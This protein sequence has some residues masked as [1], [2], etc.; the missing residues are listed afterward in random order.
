MLLWRFWCQTAT[1][2]LGSGSRCIFGVRSQDSIWSFLSCTM[3]LQGF[4]HAL[5]M[6]IILSRLSL[7]EIW[8]ENGCIAEANRTRCYVLLVIWPEF[9]SKKLSLRP[10]SGRDVEEQWD[11]FE[12]KGLAKKKRLL[13]SLALVMVHYN[14]SLLTR[15]DLFAIHVL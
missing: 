6:Q 2:T 10:N 5:V 4:N 13:R 11:N 1:F 12:S 8:K 14:H 9:A 7:A 15:H 3:F